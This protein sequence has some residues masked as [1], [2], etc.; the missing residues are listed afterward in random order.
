MAT[1]TG[2]EDSIMEELD[3]RG[4]TTD[5]AVFSTVSETDIMKVVS[6]GTDSEELSSS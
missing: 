4:G 5:E 2:R 3:S 6:M 1:V